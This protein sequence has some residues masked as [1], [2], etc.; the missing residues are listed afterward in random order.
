L[1][2]LAG[3]TLVCEAAVS[4]RPCGACRACGLVERD[5]HPDVRLTETLEGRRG[6]GIEQVRQ[7]E[8]Q[9]ALRPYESDRKALILTDADGMSDDAANALLKTLEEPPE[10]TVL[11][12]TASDASQVLPTIASRCQEVPLRPVPVKQIEAA[13]LA[14]GTSSDRAQL[15]ARLA[16]GRP[17]WA[18]A[19]AEDGGVLEARR[20]QLDQLEALLDR[21]PAERL[22]AAASFADSA[23]GRSSARAALDTWQTWWRD[24]LLVR[25]GCPELV[26]NVD[27]LEALQR[28]DVSSPECWRAVRRLQEAREQLDANANVRL[29]VEGLLL[30]LPTLRGEVGAVR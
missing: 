1:A 8:H 23:T 15:L 2:K 16:G 7:L 30:D 25:E 18:L 21:P 24:A 3:A 13:L 6:I 29:A 28:L 17:G 9:A 5:S 4:E 27:R 11:F 19:A 12:L 22:A 14:R 20:K 26:V 10:D